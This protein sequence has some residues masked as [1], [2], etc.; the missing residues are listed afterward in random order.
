MA[1]DRTHRNYTRGKVSRP[2]REW[3]VPLIHAHQRSSG[4]RRR[5]PTV[6]LRGHSETHLCGATER[7]GRVP[8]PVLCPH[9]RAV[10][11]CAA[12]HVNNAKQCSFQ[13][14]DDPHEPH[15]G[16]Q[17][18]LQRG[19]RWHSSTGVGRAHPYFGQCVEHVHPTQQSRQSQV[20]HV[21]ATYTF[22]RANRT[23]SALSLTIT[24]LTL[25]PSHNQVCALRVESELCVCLH[26]RGC[27]A[28]ARALARTFS[29][30]SSSTSFDGAKGGG[31]RVGRSPPHARN[32]HAHA[33]MH[34][35]PACSRTPQPPLLAA[36]HRSFPHMRPTLSF[37]P[38]LPSPNP[39][40]ARRRGI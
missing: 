27:W 17:N 36:A 32:T 2:G 7:N 6:S 22:G 35:V 14:S 15:V 24:S 19:E 34:C 18:E 33:R 11:T 31:H 8:V 16:D 4:C 30:T 21:L 20:D 28:R 13:P 3:G 12:F 37:T 25:T 39:N 26:G 10:W 5:N 1:H 9:E 23:V 29:S 40:Q 38:T